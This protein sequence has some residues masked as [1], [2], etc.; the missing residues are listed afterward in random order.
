TGQGGGRQ[1]RQDVAPE[2]NRRDEEAD[3]VGHVV[4]DRQGRPGEEHRERRG[5]QQATT[6]PGRK[7]LGDGRGRH[8]QGKDQEH[9][10]NLHRLR[11]GHREDDHEGDR[12]TT[13]RHALGFGNLFVEGGKEQRTVNGDERLDREESGNERD[14]DLLTR[15]T[16]DLT[17]QD[18]DRQLGRP[19][20]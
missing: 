2:R 8:D 5:K 1:P 11:N 9:A 7:S 17:E 10:D 13:N 6:R 20:V 15:D 18:A 12:Q 3:R 19:F 14:R 16:E 4:G